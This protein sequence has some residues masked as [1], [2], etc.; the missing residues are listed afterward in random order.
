MAR[1]NAM[2][3]ATTTRTQSTEALELEERKPASPRV[4]SSSEPLQVKVDWS[5][6]I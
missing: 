2:S 5:R 1:Q 4:M 3:V 6:E